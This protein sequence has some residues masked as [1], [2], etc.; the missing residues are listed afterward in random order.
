MA[1]NRKSSA[2]NLTHRP[3][4]STVPGGAV[5]GTGAPAKLIPW[6]NN[7]KLPHEILNAVM[8]SG[9]ATACWE[10]VS[11][12]LQADGF[13]NPAASVRM[14]N[15]KQT[16]DA[17]L[18]EI[19]PEISLL[20]GFALRVKYNAA[21]VPA[22]AYLVP[23]NTI[24]KLEDGTFSVNHTRGTKA[25]RKDQEEFLEP[26]NNDP[27]VVREMLQKV[28]DTAETLHD[29]TKKLHQPGQL[30]FVYRKTPRSLDY[31]LPPYWTLS[32]SKDI[33]SD[34]EISITDLDNL[35]HNFTPPVIVHFEGAVDDKEQ[36]ESGKTEYDYLEEDVASLTNKE[37]RSQ[38]VLLTGNNK[39]S[40]I[41]W[42]NSKA[43]LAMD[44]KRDTIARAVCRHW[45]VPPI[46]VGLYNSGA[47][48]QSREIL[49]AIQ[50][51]QNDINTMQNQISRVFDMLFPNPDPKFWYLSTLQPLDVIPTELLPYMNDEQ[52][53]KLID[54]YLS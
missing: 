27:E 42:D 12:Y 28:A 43:V 49:N 29:G 38:A 51:F 30:L 33:L 34:T 46:L 7:D 53:T 5:S 36:D 39:P 40:L 10:K 45:G 48:G 1:A 54:R 13:A 25:F 6:G 3:Q 41:A 50:L 2:V 35:E 31:P 23:L 26:F 19:C 37:N 17:L 32:G 14:V 20:W 18:N 21:L 4:R 24:R 9:T 47:L 16:A 22:E 11:S 44:A 15:P 52:K 8:D